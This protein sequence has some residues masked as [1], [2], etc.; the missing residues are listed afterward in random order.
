MIDIE[1]GRLVVVVVETVLIAAKSQP[2]SVL[3]ALQTKSM[4]R[5]LDY[6]LS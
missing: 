3:L 5:L 4:L 6:C 2:L 1:V